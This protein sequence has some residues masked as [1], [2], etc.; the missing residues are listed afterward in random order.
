MQVIC[1]GK[2][3]EGG[4]MLKA[5]AYVEE[6]E[7]GTLVTMSG[8]WG[9]DASGQAGFAAITGVGAV[10]GTNQIVWEGIRASKPCIAF[11]HLILMS[12]AIPDSKQKY[13]K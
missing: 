6:V 11:Q 8:E 4:T 1:D 12:I 2:A 3:I 9:L 10:T 13:A 7:E 5:M